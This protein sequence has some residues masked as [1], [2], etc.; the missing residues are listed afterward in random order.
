MATVLFNHRFM[1]GVSEA[2]PASYATGGIALDLETAIPHSAQPAAVLVDTDSTTYGAR[3]DLAN[4]K[5][6]ALVRAT[7]AEV[8]NATDLSAVTFSVVGFFAN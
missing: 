7:G 1:G 2:G 6:V 8:A 5:I 3:Y 4:K